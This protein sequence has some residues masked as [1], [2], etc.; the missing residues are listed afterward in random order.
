MTDLSAIPERANWRDYYELCKPNVVALMLLTSLI[1]MLLAVPG[2]VPIDVLILGN[3]GIA[4]CA[5]SAAAV[6]HLVD[7]QVDSKMA[8]TVNRPIATGRV[9]PREA[10][11]FAFVLGALGMC[12]LMLWI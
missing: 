6:N 9:S 4:L 8:R 2:M 11:I 3:L 5:G 1:G 10:M 12:I 7:R